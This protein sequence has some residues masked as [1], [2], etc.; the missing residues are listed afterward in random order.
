M[1]RKSLINKNDI[2][3][4]LV[5][6]ILTIVVFFQKCDSPSQVVPPTRIDTVIKYVEIHDTVLGKPKFI[7]GKKD[8]IWLDSLV[9]VPD[10]SYPKLL[11]QYKYIVDKHFT[12]NI[13]SSEFA[14]GSYGK[15]TVIDTIRGNKLIS[16]GLVYDIKVP[17][18]TITIVKPEDPKRQVYIGFGAYGNKRNFVDGVYVGGIYKDKQDRL[19]G[20]SIGYGNG[21]LN[22]GLSSYWKIKIGK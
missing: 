6:V 18:K 21:Q 5:I 16:S 4:L 3:Y 10:T 14:I 8:T 2:G 13:F 1:K 22:F 19:S 17:E 15:A 20:A 9:Y 12:T 7:K 11:Q